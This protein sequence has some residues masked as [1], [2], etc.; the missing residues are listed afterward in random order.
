MSTTFGCSARIL[1][2]TPF[3]NPSL[4]CRCRTCNRVSCRKTNDVA[5][6][7]LEEH[8]KCPL[9]SGPEFLL[10]PSYALQPRL[11]T[12]PRVTESPRSL[13]SSQRRLNKVD[14]TISTI[15]L[16]KCGSIASIMIAFVLVRL[17]AYCEAIFESGEMLDYRSD[18]W[19]AAKHGR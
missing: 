6:V 10:S 8:R 11:H 1:T 16:R 13:D 5:K 4:R 14:L 3:W 2:I 7:S 12:G 19:S 9:H 15:G 17:Q 18:R